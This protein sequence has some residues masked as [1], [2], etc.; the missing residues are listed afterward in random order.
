MTL[1]STVQ[2]ECVATPCYVEKISVLSCRPVSELS[3][4]LDV[5]ERSGLEP[6][7]VKALLKE[8]S[9]V[10]VQGK[11]VSSRPVSQCGE[12][13]SQRLGNV[14]ALKEYLVI[15]TTCEAFPLGVSTEGFVSSPCCDTLPVES[16]ECVLSIETLGP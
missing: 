2:G 7:Q 15:D 5:I 13:D 9:A 14:P 16:T 8:G 4:D 10:V 12:A 6:R 3:A 1:S 11:I